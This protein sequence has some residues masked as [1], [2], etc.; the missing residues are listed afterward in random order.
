MGDSLSVNLGEAAR[1]QIGSV[2]PG[3]D[4][5]SDG[6]S[7]CGVAHSGDYRLGGRQLQLSPTC[8]HWIETWSAA[9]ERDRPKVVVIQVGRHEVLDRQFH[10]E[11]TNILE[12]AYAEYVRTQLELA[13]GTA[14]ERGRDVV[15]LTS[16][17]FLTSDGSRP[18]DDPARVQRF[19]EIL[20]EVAADHRAYVVDLGG[21]A[22]PDGMYA[23]VVDGIKIR[24]SGV[25]YS[26][27][28]ADWAVRWLLPQL[29]P[30]LNGTHP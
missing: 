30:L 17:F 25:H 3:A 7:G 11:W 21:R 14:A 12:P 24:S 27:A 2:A 29:V 23:D 4:V 6:I 9:L 10:D 15:L 16:P 18:E 20:N 19:N 28:G 5:T 13:V 26:A 1:R 22:S 8:D